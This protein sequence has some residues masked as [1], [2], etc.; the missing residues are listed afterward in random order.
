VAHRQ[1]KRNESYQGHTLRFHERAT[2]ENQ[3]IS[4][5]KIA[6]SNL[7]FGKSVGEEKCRSNDYSF[8]ACMPT[9][10]FH[11]ALDA[12]EQPP[13]MFFPPSTLA[14]VCA[15]SLPPGPIYYPNIPEEQNEQHK[16][17]LKRTNI[18]TRYRVSSRGEGAADAFGDS[19][20]YQNI[21]S[22]FVLVTLMMCS[23]MGLSCAG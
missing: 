23:L 22:R 7:S 15:H 12:T 8:I 13:L 4:K 5:W 10:E 6:T 11:F 17:L 1:K 2:S 14:F 3:K 18:G 19:P 16:L 9:R 21:I 20:S